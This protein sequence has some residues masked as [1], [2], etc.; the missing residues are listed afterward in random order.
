VRRPDQPPTGV[1]SP[2]IGDPGDDSAWSANLAA[3]R[4]YP[5]ARQ[6]SAAP[7]LPG[8]AICSKDEPSRPSRGDEG[9][10]GNSS[11]TT[12]Q[13]YKHQTYIIN[14]GRARMVSVLL[15]FPFI[16]FSLNSAA[17]VIEQAR[18]GG[19]SQMIASV[20]AA[21]RSWRVRAPSEQAVATGHHRTPSA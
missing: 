5:S 16:P 20:P 12:H 19:N 6:R 17:T 13:R 15:L 21:A 8:L 4:R 9:R 18:A 10:S 7:T 1:G 14:T 11:T 2:M 3:R